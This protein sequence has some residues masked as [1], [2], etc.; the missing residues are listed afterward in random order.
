MY[1]FFYYVPILCSRDSL[2][3]K[4]KQWSDGVEKFVIPKDFNLKMCIDRWSIFKIS[5]DNAY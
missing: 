4:S 1:M 5:F 2:K 3:Q